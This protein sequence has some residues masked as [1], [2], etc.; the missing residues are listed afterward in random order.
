LRSGVPTMFALAPVRDL[1]FQVVAALGFRIRPEKEFTRILQLGQFGES[2]ETY[3][4]NRE[5]LMVSN[6]RFDESLILLGLLPDL[7]DA[8]SLLTLSMRDPGGNLL[9]GFRPGV[10]RAELPLTKAASAAVSGS[11]GYDLV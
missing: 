4:I 1:N 9:E 11:S 10:R 8:R 5:G 7:D 2:G 6:S 3:A